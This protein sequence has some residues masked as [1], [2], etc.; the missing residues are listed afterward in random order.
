MHIEVEKSQK[1]Y[2][3]KCLFKWKDKYSLEKSQNENVLT[4]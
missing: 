3:L 4:S 1:I 2:A